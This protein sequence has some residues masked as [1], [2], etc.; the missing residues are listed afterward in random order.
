MSAKL[1]ALCDKEAAGFASI[2]DTVN[3]EKFYCHGDDDTHPT[4][5]E[6]ALRGPKADTTFHFLTTDLL[7]TSTTTSASL[8][9][10]PE[11]THI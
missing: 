10:K 2:W 5:Y 9:A 3:G 4:C 8:D 6:L 7:R 1:C 11:G